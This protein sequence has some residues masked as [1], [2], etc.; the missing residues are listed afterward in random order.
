MFAI[1]A[2]APTRIDLAGGTLDLWPL[3]H[4]MSHK[5]TVNVGVDIFANVEI[6]LSND[7]GYHLQSS[8]QNVFVDGNFSEICRNKKLALMSILLD[9][10]WKEEYPA[11]TIRTYAH[12]PKGAG[13]G[14]SSS[15]GV[16]VAGALNYARGLFLKKETLSE[17]ALVK[18]VCNAEAKLLHIPTG[19]QDHWGAMRGALNII[20][21]PLS[22]ET[23]ETLD[24][25][26]LN[27]LG[28]GLVLCYSGEPRN[29]GETNWTF[30][31]R[32]VEGD[33][34]LLGLLEELGVCAEECSLQARRGD[35]RG[36][37]EYSSKEWELRK[38]IWPSCQT[39]KTQKLEEIGCAAGADFA[40]ICGAGGGGV[41]L[42]FCDIKT[43][44]NVIK[45]LN[46][47]GG[48][49]LN[50]QPVRKGLRIWEDKSSLDNLN[51]GFIIA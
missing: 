25:P 11:L 34:K 23:I 16:A 36:V 44:E 42:F 26:L 4:F 21:Y 27:E 24:S 35:Y 12:S 41:M 39:E 33:K 45:S 6:T 19:F 48:K 29:S 50:A 46:E 30:F 13:L 18:L 32:A 22:G 14:G 10:L 9:A 17:E 28:R 2:Q 38:K 5:C 31:K 3:H 20:E 7:K 40:R 15:L 47:S 37:L 43:R 8:D 49:V 51:D 1:K